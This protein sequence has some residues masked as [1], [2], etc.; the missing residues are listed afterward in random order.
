MREEKR[1]AKGERLKDRVC[2]DF[3]VKVALNENAGSTLNPG[4]TGSNPLPSLLGVGF[5][6]L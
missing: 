3:G 6:Q 2:P 5:N 4:E 1:K